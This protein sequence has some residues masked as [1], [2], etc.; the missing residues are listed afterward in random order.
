MGFDVFFYFSLLHFTCLL[1][2]PFP[3]FSK[4]RSSLAFAG[5]VFLNVSVADPAAGC[6]GWWVPL[7]PFG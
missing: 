1:F 5:W 2:S 6:G 7:V 3:L 4:F